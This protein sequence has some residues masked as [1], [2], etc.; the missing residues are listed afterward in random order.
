M[1][2]KYL[3]LKHTILIYKEIFHGTPP[4]HPKY[5]IDDGSI[6]LVRLKLDGKGEG[7]KQCLYF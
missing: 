7:T 2:S 1:V 4:P 3:L 6:A 5:E